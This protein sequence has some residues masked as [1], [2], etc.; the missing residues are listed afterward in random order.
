MNLYI[1]L[2]KHV[3]FL[4]TQIQI[5]PLKLPAD[6]LSVPPRKQ[7]HFGLESNMLIFL[8]Y[9]MRMKWEQWRT[10]WTKLDVPSGLGPLF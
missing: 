6:A 1:K 8:T 10:I 9:S 5:K 7:N 2:N 3:N 4:K